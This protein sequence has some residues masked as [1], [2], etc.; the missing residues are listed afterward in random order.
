M[1]NRKPGRPKKEQGVPPEG[2]GAAPVSEFHTSVEQKIDQVIGGINVLAA[3]VGKLVDM[4]SSNSA[5]KE[6]TTASS[7]QKFNPK[8]EDSTYPQVYIPPKYRQLVDDILSPEFGISVTDF[9]DR[10]DFQIHVIVPEKYSSIS[11]DD[12]KKGIQDI[13]SRMIPRSLGENGV[14]EWVT[15][16]RQNLNK[17]YTKEGKASPFQN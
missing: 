3:A 4:Q 12:R 8:M 13:R 16:I 1:A 5:A 15:L 6:A 14:R 9:D 2:T 7:D 11:P 17:Y 10:T